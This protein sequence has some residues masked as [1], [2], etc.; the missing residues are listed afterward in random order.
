MW[1]RM[2]TG[3][4]EH[5]AKE[6]RTEGMHDRRNAGHEDC[7]T[8]GMMDVSK[9]SNV[10]VSFLFVFYPKKCTLRFVFIIKKLFPLQTFIFFF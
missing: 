2:D 5:R 6:C 8:G 10:N 7:T 4:N 9:T 3:P 1:D